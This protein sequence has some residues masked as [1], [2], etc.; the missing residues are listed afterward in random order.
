[1]QE[2][3]REAAGQAAAACQQREAK[4]LSYYKVRVHYLQNIDKRY[5]ND[6]QLK[7]SKLRF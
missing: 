2:A 5:K 6:K 1:M 7:I 3:G 4:A